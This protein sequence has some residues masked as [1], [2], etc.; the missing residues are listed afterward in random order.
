MPIQR[1]PGAGTMFGGT[2]HG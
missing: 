1:L 2:L